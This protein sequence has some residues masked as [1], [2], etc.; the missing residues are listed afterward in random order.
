MKI[1]D[2]KKASRRTLL[3]GSSQT[4]MVLV[5]SIIDCSCKSNHK[6]IEAFQAQ[7]I[8]RTK[9]IFTTNRQQLPIFRLIS[10]KNFI[11]SFSLL[12]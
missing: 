5:A 1:K 7:L 8:N 10:M 12:R 3:D 9:S 4:K 11:D 6:T 2:I